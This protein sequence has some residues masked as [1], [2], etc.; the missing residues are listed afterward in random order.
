MSGEWIIIINRLWF[1][2]ALV[3]SHTKETEACK[4]S[5]SSKDFRRHK[6]YFSSLRELHFSILEEHSGPFKK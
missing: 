4:S 1:G 3:T 6:R 5:F 2:S